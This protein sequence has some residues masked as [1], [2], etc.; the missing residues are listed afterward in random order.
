M[1]G[2]SVFLVAGILALAFLVSACS[3]SKSQT[4]GSGGGVD[5]SNFNALGTF[6]IVKEKETINVML[7]ATRAEFN[8]DTNWMTKFYEDKT[9]VHVNWTIVPVAQYKEKV[10]LALASDEPLDLIVAGGHSQTMFVMTDILKFAEQGLILPIQDYLESDSVYFKQR[11]DEIPGWRNVITLPNGGIYQYPSANDC[12]H[13]QYYEKEW[14][15]T[16][17]LKNLNLKVPTTIEEFHDMLVA[18]KTRDANGNGDP[19]DEIPI[20]GAIDNF[21]TKVSSYL[22]NA[23]IFD[24]GLN[25]LFLENGKVVAAFTRPEYQEGLKY[26]NQLYK[27]GLVSKDSFTQTGANRSKLNS[28]KYESIIGVIPNTHHGGMGS[29]ET[30]EPVRWIDYEPIPPLKGPHGMQI[31][32]YSYY[33]KFQTERAAAFLPSSSKNPALVTRWL[34]WLVSDEGTMTLIFGEKGTSWTDA[35]PGTTGPDG[36][37]AVYKTLT[38]LPTHPLYNNFNWDQLFP[39][40]RTENFR[41]TQQTPENMRDPT[42][43]GAERF[44]Y[45]KTKE[46]YAPYGEPLDMLFPPLYYATEDVSEIATLTTNINTYVEESIAK[47]IVGDLNINTDWNA[48][49]TNLK[50]LG[51]D[52]YI[53]INQK[54]YDGSAFAK[55]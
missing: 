49:Q 33:D 19:N 24:D 6:P 27:E 34:D 1:R 43:E 14:V 25:R 48:F 15:N 39:N 31:T 42:G 38:M 10:N 4:Q 18:F 32:R 29:R 41:L 7:A 13:C 21:G 45:I 17:F 37:P 54:T 36:R 11:L 23:F 9:N 5:R 55:K 8:A 16:E 47:F 26:I 28:V 2:R 50:N 22:M 53:E 52:R 40:F 51:I 3:G 30:G 12:F 46:N 44:L 20:M 35:D